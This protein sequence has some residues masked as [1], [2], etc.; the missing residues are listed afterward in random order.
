MCMGNDAFAGAISKLNVML[1]A[2]EPLLPVLAEAFHARTPARLY[3]LY[4]PTEAS[5][6]ATMTECPPGARRI[7]IGRPLDNCRA[8]VL[9]GNLQRVMPTARGE[10]CIAG[11][12]L[13]RG[14]VNQPGLTAAAFVDDPFFPGKRMYRSGDIGRLLPD[15][16]IEYIGRR[17]SQIKIN[18]QRVELGEITAR[19]AEIPGVAEVAAVAVSSENEEKRIRACAVR[20]EGSRVAEADIRE[21]LSK[22]LPP[23]MMP[24]EIWLL[25]AMPRNASGKTDV[26][27]LSA[28]GAPESLWA[29]GGEKASSAVTAAAEPAAEPSAPAVEPEDEPAVA[30]ANP[31]AAKEH[32]AESTTDTL[33]EIWKQALGRAEVDLHKTFFEQGGGSLAAL[34]ALSRCYNAGLNL[35]LSEFY[36]HPTIGAQ[37]AL[38]SG[39][40]PGGREEKPSQEAPAAAGEKSA[41]NAGAEDARKKAGAPSDGVLLTGATGFLGAHLLNELADGMKR[42]VVCL[43]RGGDAAR[44]ARAMEDYFG[45]GWYAR[46]A[47]RVRVVPG[48]MEQSDFGI[49]EAELAELAGRVGTLLHCAADVRHY[50]A[51]PRASVRANAGGTA[52]AIR[53]AARLGAGLAYVSTMSVAGEGAGEAFTEESPPCELGGEGN[54][55]VRGKC[56]AERL[57]MKCA[58]M[59]PAARIFR[60]GRLVGRNSDGVFQKNRETNAFYNF[61]RGALALEKYP[62]GMAGL[63]LELTPVDACARAIAL[64]LEGRE[65]VYHIFD[66]I[67]VEF[68]ELVATLTGREV[69]FVPDAEFGEY[70]RA[71]MAARPSAGLVMLRELYDA[72]RRGRGEGETQASAKRTCAELM[73]KGFIWRRA[74]IS[75]ALREFLGD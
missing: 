13:A 7:T 70:L 56:A 19:L 69:T 8:Y 73:E 27:A 44:L 63:A 12:C 50:T 33:M 3:N 26:F 47:S 40:A 17:D 9:D 32:A 72:S 48:D 41:R 45:A 43:V 65:S 53:L 54:A 6:Y 14:Y 30:A 59:L 66:P 20:A 57:V 75:V 4:G 68:G 24:N 38:L 51:D 11:V 37:A 31:A 23:F 5:V 61:L 1:V 46:N 74:D 29:P 28:V 42:S 60:V 55:Y 35:T 15:G 52:N 25:P 58:K 34:D 21:E 22:S 39:G 62:A 36:E 18:G 64:L 10:I 67:R 2:G 49:G 71:R 16:N